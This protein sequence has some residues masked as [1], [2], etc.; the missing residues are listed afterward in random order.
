MTLKSISKNS[1]LTENEILNKRLTQWLNNSEM[2]IK[3][4]EE[5]PTPTTEAEEGEE[6]KSVFHKHEKQDKV[7]NAVVFSGFVSDN[8]VDVHVNQTKKKKNKRRRYSK[9]LLLIRAV[10][11][12]TSFVSYQF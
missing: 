12:E 1:T 8:V 7:K 9:F 4:W 3:G 11:L 5:P 10:L 6:E 2:G